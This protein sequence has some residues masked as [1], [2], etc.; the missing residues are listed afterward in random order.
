MNLVR[1]IENLYSRGLQQWQLARENYAS[2]SHMKIKHFNYNGREIVAQFNPCRHKSATA[3]VD[4]LSISERECFLCSSHQ[5]REQES[6][7]WDS[8]YKIQINPYPIFNRHLTLSSI[9]HRPQAIV[10]FI[11]DMMSMAAALPGYVLFY[12]GPACGASAPDHMHFQAVPFHQLPLCREAINDDCDLSV[13]FP[14]FYIIRT[15]KSE[16]K[17]WFNVTE[18]GMRKIH[19]GNDEPPQNVLCWKA[20]KQWH[21]IIIPRSKHRPA[22]YGMGDEEFLLSPA[23]VEL[24]GVWPITR[25]SDFNRITPSLLQSII[26]EVTIR[27]DDKNIILDY[28]ISHVR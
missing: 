24:T 26:E 9:E 17:R 10:P 25:E 8:R 2:L 23:T 15:R 19:E 6:I 5:P 27:E 11:D 21:I 28:F 16:A 22:C 4:A 12:N 13:Y 3:S 1:D 20:K 14:F 18:K 7:I